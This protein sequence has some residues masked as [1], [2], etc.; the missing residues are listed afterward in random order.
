MSREV[1]MKPMYQCGECSTLFLQFDIHEL[2]G[3]LYELC[4]NPNC[5]GPKT[6][7]GPIVDAAVWWLFNHILSTSGIGEAQMM[8]LRCIAE[9]EMGPWHNSYRFL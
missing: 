8:H 1:E 5:H 7:C 3:K 9:T 4:P 2:E 6:K